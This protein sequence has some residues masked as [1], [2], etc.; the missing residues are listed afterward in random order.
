MGT[1][2]HEN[3]PKELVDRINALGENVIKNAEELGL[4]TLKADSVAR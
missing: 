1:V 4:I 2:M 3:A